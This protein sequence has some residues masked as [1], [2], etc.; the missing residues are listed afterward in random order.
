MADN[1]AL[2]TGNRARQF[3][4]YWIA[5]AESGFGT[6]VTG[7]ALPLTALLV[8]RASTM[9]MALLSAAGYIAWIIIGLPAGAIVTYLP[10]RGTQVTLDLVRAVAIASVPLAWWVGILSFPHLLIVAATVSFA[11]VIFETANAT[12]LPRIVNRA[13]LHRRNSLMS[14]T[15][16]ANN[17]GGPSLGSVLIQALGPIPTLLVDSVSYLMSG[18]LLRTLPPAEANDRPGDRSARA[19]VAEGWRYVQGERIVAASMWS[20]ALTNLIAGGYSALFTLYLIRVL[21]VPVGLVGV[22][23]AT[24]TVGALTA[25]SVAT[26]LGHRA[27]MRG[28]VL[29]GVTMT[30]A[31]AILIPVGFGYAGPIMFALGTL[32]NSAG[33][34][35]TSTVTRTYRQLVT[36]KNL[37]PSVTAT[38]RFISWGAIPV[39]SLL[40]GFI[41]DIT[42]IRLTLGVLAITSIGIAVILIWSPLHRINVEVESH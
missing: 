40:F 8:L 39:G 4:I 9:D 27:G 17:I 12:F 20:A 16:A 34:V 5:S 6:A 10:L 19:I 24:G 7:V 1:V 38:V 15:I 33:V 21:H 32:L 29:T 3:W 41:A 35:L 26:S 14:G 31:G 23:L 37:L 42:D 25:A 30:V 22:L 28:T 13:E 11:D 2:Q 36:P 18:I